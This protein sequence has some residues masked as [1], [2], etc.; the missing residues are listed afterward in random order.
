[1]IENVS[2]APVIA[3]DLLAL[4]QDILDAQFEL[5]SGRA[6]L[7]QNQAYAQGAFNLGQRQLNTAFE[8]SYPQVAASV[9]A[10]GFGNSGQAAR[11]ISR[12][13]EDRQLANDSLGLDYQNQVAGFALQQQALERYAQQLQLLQERQAVYAG[14]YG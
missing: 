9:A 14:L 5:S 8:R 3:E 11:A 13:F 12:A 2:T 7:G 6:Q 1:M 10:S 4:A